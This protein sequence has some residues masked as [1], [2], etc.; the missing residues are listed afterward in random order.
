MPAVSVL[1]GMARERRASI[2]ARSLVGDRNRLHLYKG[3]RTPICD[4]DIPVDDRL[5]QYRTHFAQSG[6]GRRRTAG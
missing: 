4:T 6:S 5:V 1:P 3:I 2:Q